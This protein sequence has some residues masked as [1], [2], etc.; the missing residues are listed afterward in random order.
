MM[1]EKSSV[2]TGLNNSGNLEN[3]FSTN[4]ANQCNAQTPNK[5]NNEM[6]AQT[7]MNREVRNKILTKLISFENSNSF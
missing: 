5:K 4:T 3:I 6:K 1:L 7:N 2:E